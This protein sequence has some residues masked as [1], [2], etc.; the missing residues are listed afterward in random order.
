MIRRIPKGSYCDQKPLSAPKRVKNVTL[1]VTNKRPNRCHFGHK[2]TQSWGARNTCGRQN[3]RA[4]APTFSSSLSTFKQS[5]RNNFISPTH[6]EEKWAE[7]ACTS[8][9]GNVP[10]VES[11]TEITVGGG[12]CFESILSLLFLSRKLFVL[13]CTAIFKHYTT[14]L[15]F[16]ET[17]T[18]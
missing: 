3:M 2:G 6:F 8:S 15:F 18:R 7:S 5:L 9:L 11:H 13:C 14:S 10:T 1:F 4:G 17:E 12:V 16:S